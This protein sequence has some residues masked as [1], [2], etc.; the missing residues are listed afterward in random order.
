MNFKSSIQVFLSSLIFLTFN[1]CQYIARNVDKPPLITPDDKQAI[2]KEVYWKI[3]D[4]GS[5]DQDNWENFL[6]NS[7]YRLAQPSDFL[8]DLSSIKDEFL[9]ID[10]QKAVSYPCKSSDLNDD[11]RSDRVC[12]MVDRNNQTKKKF[13]LIVI[14]GSEIK[15][16]MPGE[17]NSVKW[18]YKDRDLSRYL[19]SFNVRGGGV[20]LTNDLD[21][22]NIKACVV[23][24]N[25]VKKKYECS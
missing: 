18:I 22:K 14:E 25:N 6:K 5:V 17:F 8:V 11:G 15:D 1:G 4:E 23:F 13:S 12:M 3:F 10:I 7:S 16:T 21:P 20:I 2:Q 24:W 9:R 19:L